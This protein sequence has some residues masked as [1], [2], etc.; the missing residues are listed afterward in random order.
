MPSEFEVGEVEAT[1]GPTPAAPETIG[2]RYGIHETRYRALPEVGLQKHL[3]EPYLMP[4][5]HGRNGSLE[6]VD[7]AIVQTP[8][9]GLMPGPMAIPPAVPAGQVGAFPVKQTTFGQ[10]VADSWPDGCPVPVS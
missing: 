8:L 7:P 9:G 10:G 4:T 2:A 1:Q 3:T 5:V 6:K